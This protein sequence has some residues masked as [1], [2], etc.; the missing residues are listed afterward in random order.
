MITFYIALA[1][2]GRLDIE[3]YPAVTGWVSQIQH[4]PVTWVC[5]VCGKAHKLLSLT[6]L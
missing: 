1:P 4:C 6:L 3:S 2:E 5:P